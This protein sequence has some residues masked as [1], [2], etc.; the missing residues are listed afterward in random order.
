MYQSAK[1]NILPFISVFSTVYIYLFSL[2]VLNNLIALRMF[3]DKNPSQ[4]TKL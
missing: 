2:L 1:L 3:S 4:V